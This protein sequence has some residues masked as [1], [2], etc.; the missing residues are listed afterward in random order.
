MAIYQPSLGE[1]LHLRILIFDL[2]GSFHNPLFNREKNKKLNCAEAI[3][4]ASS[5]ARS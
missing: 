2:L 4:A 3:A 5:M 1:S